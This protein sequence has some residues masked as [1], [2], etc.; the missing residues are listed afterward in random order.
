MHPP[1]EVWVRGDEDLLRE[2]ILNIAT[3]AVEAMPN[4]GNLQLQLEQDDDQAHITVADTGP[5]ISDSVSERI[6]DLY[7]TTKKNG[8]GLG[9]PM[10]FR[11][12]QLHGGTMRFD[13]KP[14]RAPRFTYFF[15]TIARRMPRRSDAFV[16]SHSSSG[17][18]AQHYELLLGGPAEA[19][20]AAEPFPIPKEADSRAHQE[21]REAGL[22]QRSRL[23]RNRCGRRRRRSRDKSRQVWFSRRRRHRRAHPA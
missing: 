14:N 23:L 17:V 15:R 4:G 2:C 11:A 16:A 6:F 21:F 7:Y 12:V 22:R 20:P 13:S 9:L 3:N 8:S 19:H 10:A 1:E 18:A 5:G